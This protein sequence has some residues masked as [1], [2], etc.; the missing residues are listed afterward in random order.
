MKADAQGNQHSYVEHD[1]AAFSP[2]DRNRYVS[3]AGARPMTQEAMSPNKRKSLLKQSQ[4][5]NNVFDTRNSNSK[6]SDELETK[7]FL[8]HM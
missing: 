5:T 8:S 6:K 1:Y 2:E 3:F 7:S 4:N